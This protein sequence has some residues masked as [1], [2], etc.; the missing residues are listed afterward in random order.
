MKIKNTI[1]LEHIYPKQDWEKYS[2]DLI[3]NIN[4]KPSQF[5]IRLK[6][7]GTIMIL[8]DQYLNKVEVDNFGYPSD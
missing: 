1:D 8:T 7:D 5:A 2:L 6:D 3:L 4:G